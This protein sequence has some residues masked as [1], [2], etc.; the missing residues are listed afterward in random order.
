MSFLITQAIN[1]LVYSTLLFLLSVGLS[2]I[3]GLMGVVNLAHGSFFMLGAFTAITV[4]KLTGSFWA[5]LLIAPLPVAIAAV[6][7][8]LGFLRHLYARTRLDQVLLTFGFSFIFLD[9]VKW[10]WGADLQSLAEPDALD[11]SIELLGGIFP[12][13]RLALLG[14]GLVIA[15]ALWLI[16]ERTRIG[17]MVRA[18]VDDTATAI[19]IG[20]NVPLLFT[21]T[22]AGGAALAALTGV[23]AAPILGV[24]AGM[25]VDVLIP[26]FIVIVIGGMGSLK[27]ALLG[28]LL[29]GVAETFGRAYLPDAS[30]FLTYLLMII[31]LLVRPSGLFGRPGLGEGD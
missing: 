28:S 29:I 21:A 31:V 4:V 8:E 23:A 11:G 12:S 17:A 2:L 7:M 6:V 9:L 3:F 27:G 25:D 24:Y 18:G 14:R 15:I 10:I 22:F 30:M 20:I 16:L 5:A 13:Y 1:G 19:G 26:S